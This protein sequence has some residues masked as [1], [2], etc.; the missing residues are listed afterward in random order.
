MGWVKF[1]AAAVIVMFVCLGGLG[2]YVLP[3]MGL[4]ASTARMVGAAIGGVII[5]ILFTRM[6]PGQAA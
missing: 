2:G 6:R 4:D 5:A 1:L 3:R